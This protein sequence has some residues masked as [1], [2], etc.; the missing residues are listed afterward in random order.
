MRTKSIKFR[1]KKQKDNSWIYG[2]IIKDTYGH[3]RI[4]FDANQFSQVVIPETIGQFTGL[5]DK[6]GVNIYEGDMI[7]DND[8]ILDTGIIEFCCGSFG[9]YFTPPILFCSL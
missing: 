8:N 1:G 7:K 6:N 9:V 5:T 3:Y 4:Q 2:L